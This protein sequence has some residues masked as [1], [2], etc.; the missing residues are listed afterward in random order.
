[1]WEIFYVVDNKAQ[2]ISSD[3]LETAQALWDF[4]SHLEYVTM[5]SK[6]P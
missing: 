2:R 5:K 6:R 4:L 3:D 1:M